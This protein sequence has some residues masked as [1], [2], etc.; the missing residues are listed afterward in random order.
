MTLAPGFAD[1][2]LDAAGAFRALLDAMA[3][4]GTVRA[5]GHGLRPP[6][7][8]SPAAT[9]ALLTLA[10]ADAPVWLAP[11]RRS[12]D[13][14][15]FLRFHLAAAPAE[16]PADA[17]FAIGRWDELGAI[18]DWAIGTPEYPDRSATL[19]VE[20]DGLAEGA[21]ARLTGPGIETAR[22][23]RV[24]GASAGFWPFVVANRALFPLGVDLILTCG[25][26]VAA[27]PRSV[28]ADI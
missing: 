10:D 25:A 3:R 4:P 1:P 28:R 19:I 8:L 21:G 17:A 27:L 15:E 18:E 14:A 16:R 12:A 24:E 6:A 20:V 7:P 22:L 13:I 9:A 23:L 2:V 5:L 26:Q 11:S